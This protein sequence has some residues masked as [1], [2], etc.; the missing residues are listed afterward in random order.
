[1]DD[2]KILS[3]LKVFAMKCIAA[4]RYPQDFY[5][6]APK[7]CPKCGLVP[8]ELIIEHHT[9]S[10]KSNFRG[11]ISAKCSVCGVTESIFSFT[12]KHRKVMRKEKPK[13]ICNND[14]FIAA[15][16]ERFEQAGGIP[17]FFDE[18]IVV[19]KCAACS[20]NRSFVFTD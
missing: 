19:G 11:I 20:R 14:K 16:C 17:G 8:L 5:I 1:M 15:E 6:F 7:Q 3:D 13:C 12:G 18:G 10:K 9:G 2:E 4:D